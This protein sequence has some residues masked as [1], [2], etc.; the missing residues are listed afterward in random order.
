MNANIGFNGTTPANSAIAIGDGAKSNGNNAVAL[1]QGALASWDSTGALALGA[2]ALVEGKNQ[3]AIGANSK[4]DTP[5]LPTKSVTINGTSYDFAGATDMSSMA[6]FSIGNQAFK[7]LITNVA[8]GALSASSTDG[9]NGSQLFATN[10]ELNKL[11]QR[12]NSGGLGLTVQ[13][14]LTRNL[15][16]GAGVDGAAVDFTNNGKKTR[17]LTGLTNGDVKAGSTDAVTGDQLFT[18]TNDINL[19][20]IGLVRQADATANLTVGMA[21]GG[22]A[23]DFRG[24]GGV[25]RRLIGVADGAED[26]A[27]LEAINGRQLS[28]R[29][30]RIDNLYNSLVSTIGGVGTSRA[31]GV[32]TSPVFAVQGNTF[33]TVEA[34]FAGVSAHFNLQDSTITT[35]NNF[36]VKYVWDDKNGDGKFDDG[37]IDY[38]RVA[39]TGSGGTTISNVANGA[40]TDKSSEAIN[41]SQ[42]FG[43][44]KNI[45]AY[46]GGGAGVGANGA[47]TAPKYDITAINADKTTSTSSYNNVGAALGGLDKNITNINTRVGD[48]DGR[49]T[50]HEDNIKT[51]N[52]SITNINSGTTGLVQQSAKGANLTI[53]KD[54]DGAAVDLTGIFTGV[55]GPRKLIGLGA[56]TLSETSTEAVNGSQL[57]QTRS[58]VAGFLGGGAS[59]GADGTFT[60]P[61]YS[62]TTIDAKGTSTPETFHDVGGAFGGLNNSVTNINTR[63]G[64]IDGRVSAIT[65]LAGNEANGSGVR[66]VRTNEKTL[67][68]DDAFALGVGSTAIGYQ[69]RAVEAGSV[70]LGQNSITAAATRVDG[71]K[72]NGG[73]Y[74]FATFAPTDPVTGGP[75]PGSVVSVGSGAIK[76]QI[77]N[78]AA[79]QLGASS[80]DAVN[81]SQLD[82]TNLAVIAVD[83]RVNQD[84]DKITNLAAAFG[85]GATVDGEVVSWTAPTYNITKIDVDGKSTS[86]TVHDVGSALGGLN[87]SVTNINTR[88]GD[89][90]GR[91][92]KTEGDINTINT[93]IK[94]INSGTAGLVQQAKAGDNLTIGKDTDGAAIDLKGKSARKLLSLAAGDVAKDSTDG[95]NGGQLFDTRS[96]I[97]SALGGGSSVGAD[98][99]FTGPTY[100]ITTIDAKGTS[101]PETFH[102]VG[103]AFVG[104]NNSVTNINTR[105]GDIATQMSGLLSDALLWDPTNSVYS[106]KHGTSATNRIADVA[107]GVKDTDAVNVKQLNDVDAKSGDALKRVGE[108]AVKYAWEDKNGNGVVDP[109][110]AIDYSKIVLEGADNIGTKIGNVAAGQVSE[111]SLEAINGSQLWGVSNKIA[112]FL[113]GDAS[114]DANGVFTGPSYKVTN[115]NSNG[116]TSSTSY[117]NVGSALGGLNDNTTNINNRINEITKEVTTLDKDSLRWDEQKGV[118]TALRDQPISV[119]GIT[120]MVPGTSKIT[121][122]TDGEVNAT[123]TDAVTG[124]QL[125]ERDERIT[126]IDHR[127]TKIETTVNTDITAA[128]DKT[129]VKYAPDASGNKTNEVALVGGDPNAPVLISNVKAGAADNDAVNVRQLKETITQET[130]RVNQYLDESKTYT[131]NQIASL[132][133][134]TDEKFGIVDQKLDQLSSDIGAVRNE[135]RQAAAIG[136]AA[137][138][139]RF[140]NTPGKISVAMGG[141]VWRDQGAV[142]F[143]AGYTSESGAIRANLS[144][145]ASGGEVG[146]GAGLSFTLN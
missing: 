110:E 93:S 14:T 122:I 12:M 22:A 97:A 113:G 68:P 21:T 49:V 121:N 72:I 74:S 27:S 80:T 103:G 130:T 56:A 123:S 91:V 36:A 99:T 131:N 39:L 117:S 98:G 101:T 24:T 35:L 64:D 127:V 129:A 107:T 40:V 3:V 23:V 132:R 109:G 133:S 143:G 52:T 15:T 58:S 140:D 1:G 138:S 126:N 37:E 95:V 11:G 142:A 70:A 119:D 67:I 125:F 94:N 137:S 87:N 81:G 144:G 111:K 86:N 134:D 65:A 25:A 66:Y 79:G 75:N 85:G 73:T 29:D 57:F 13:D 48:I 115:I 69:A 88:V 42:L 71:I 118:F 43:V 47:L 53:G 7:R 145:V 30:A 120:K 61:T 17:K 78:V 10:S 41:G 82:A 26:G 106:A 96:S 4:A 5:A 108:R 89:I 102:D 104:L 46:L 76:R 18:T 63:V 90:D 45:A 16:V 116:S 112:G 50:K 38:K 54:T 141:G 33:N 2:G 77:I 105:V 124:A 92:V 31:T 135:A 44:S 51:I 128:M 59:V 139:L 100:S 28:K 62:I 114:V 60:G 84:Q 19:G 20:R 8:A 34:A 136:L 83:E 146:V 32:F 9:V 6:T 55:K